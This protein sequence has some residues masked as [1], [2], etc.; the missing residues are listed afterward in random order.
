M[1]ESTS[2]HLSR[3]RANS[4]NRKNRKKPIARRR[5]PPRRRM[6]ELL[7]LLLCGF[8]LSAGVLALR[9][10]EARRWRANLVAY[11]LRFP[12]DL[13]TASVTNFIR[14]I[15]GIVASRTTRPFTVR[16]VVL[17]VTG[18]SEGLRHHLLV[19]RPLAA[20]VLASLRA[21]LPQ[22]VAERDETF[23]IKLPS[24]AAEV[25]L[26]GVHQ[27]R[28]DN[29]S[30]VSAALLSAISTRTTGESV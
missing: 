4:K 3:S 9:L 6:V 16:A 19:P 17:N 22:V 13:K 20:I 15:S 1:F 25:G 29:Q 2:G 14:G 18:S 11:E 5:R 7:L 27:L 21:A 8:G 24:L 30:A 26:R 23:E 10:G 28:T 12:R